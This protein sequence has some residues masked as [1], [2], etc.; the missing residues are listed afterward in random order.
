MNLWNKLN[1]KMRLYMLVM[2]F[3]WIVAF[4]FLGIFYYR[5]KEFK[6]E[7]LNAHLQI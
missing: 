1:Y 3:T 5:E 4:V 7:T 6:A 2:V